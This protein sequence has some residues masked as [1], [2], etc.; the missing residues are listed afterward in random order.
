MAIDW[1]DVRYRGDAQ[2]VEEL[3]RTYRV[4]DYLATFEAHERR[5][6]HG[7]REQLLKDG[8]RLSERLSPR[9]Y[10]LFQEVSQALEI[11]PAA[12]IFC[13]PSETIN[14]FALVEARES[15]TRTLIGITAAALERLEDSEL[16]A[17]IGHELGHFLFG[18]NRFLGLL[19]SDPQ[20]ASVTVLPA[21]GESLFLRWK[22]KAELSADRAGL[23]ASR[24]FAPA[25]RTLLKA[26]Y[27]L[28]EKNLNLDVEALLEQIGEIEGRRELIDEA[29]ASHPL[30]PIRLKALELFS[31]SA[32]AQRTGYPIKGTPIPDEELE[33]Q[34]DRLILMTRRFPSDPLAQAV[35]RS[36]AMGGVILL[37]ADKEIS[38]EEVKV[39]VQILHHYFT[40]EPE[41]EI[42]TNR[43]EAETNLETALALVN[44]EGAPGDKLFLLSRLIDVA[45]ADGALLEAE[46][47]FIL[48]LGE[49]LGIPSRTV[50]P[51]MIQG[52]NSFGFKSD[53]RLNRITASLRQSLQRAFLR[54]PSLGSGTE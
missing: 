49:R 4:E 21:M 52:A 6:D 2:D 10:R 28:T 44:R 25:A 11:P 29:F 12:E 5:Q 27:G 31:R 34:V 37:G 7:F 35:M 46:G 42:V 50:Y 22:K 51:M 20:S 40:D 43:K 9:I 19:S 53:T 30:L 39:L 3:I 54:E 41:Q 26:A 8:V 15:E 1:N 23:L 24:E 48:T 38:D 47:S 18:T 45:L 33:S 36:V 13:L 32:K 14:A 16:R 17:L